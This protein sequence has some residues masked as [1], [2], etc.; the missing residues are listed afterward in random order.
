[1]K[2]RKITPYFD[3]KSDNTLRRIEE[4]YLVAE[5]P[6]KISLR[7]LKIINYFKISNIINDTFYSIL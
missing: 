7:I 4:F 2:I 6:V 5:R 1:M 3:G